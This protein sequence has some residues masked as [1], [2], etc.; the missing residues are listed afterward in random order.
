MKDSGKKGCKLFISQHITLHSLFASPFLLM[1]VV[2]MEFGFMLSYFLLPSLNT[3]KYILIVSLV[4]E[5][6]R[7]VSKCVVCVPS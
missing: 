7:Y 3:Y 4:S 5:A 6:R 1:Q 2:K